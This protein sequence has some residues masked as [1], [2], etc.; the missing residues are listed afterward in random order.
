MLGLFLRMATTPTLRL[1]ALMATFRLLAATIPT[2]H[3]RT[4]IMPTLRPR[5]VTN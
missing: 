5:K 2:L 4:A 3:P 1:T